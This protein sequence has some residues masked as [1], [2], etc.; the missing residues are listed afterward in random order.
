MASSQERDVRKMLGDP[1]EEDLSPELIALCQRQADG[2][3]NGNLINLYKRSIPFSPVPDQIKTWAEQVTSALLLKS[4]GFRLMKPVDTAQVQADYDRTVQEVVACGRGKI[5]LSGVNPHGPA[6]STT[7]G[8]ER[9]FGLDDPLNWQID[10]DQ[11][12]A[13]ATGR[14]VPSGGGFQI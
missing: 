4:P 6:K 10:P 7:S 3:I 11:A 2:F 1:S 5:R 12:D 8:Y 13:I 14:K 9:T